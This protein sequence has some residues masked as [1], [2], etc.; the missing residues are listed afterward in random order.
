MNSLTMKNLFKFLKLTILSL[1]ILILICV[2]VFY[3]IPYLTVE[4]VD[5]GP[6]PP[7]LVELQKSFDKKGYFTEDEMDKLT[8]IRNEQMEKLTKIR[9]EQI[10]DSTHYSK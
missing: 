6:A 2:A 3:A 9:K 7:E 4:E 5:M 10:Q 8:K 1:L